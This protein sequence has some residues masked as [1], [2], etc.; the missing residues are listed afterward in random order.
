MFRSTCFHCFAVAVALLV[1]SPPSA[2]AI[3]VHRTRLVLANRLLVQWAREGWTHVALR[4]RARD[5]ARCVLPVAASWTRTPT[6]PTDSKAAGELL[7]A[8]LA[9]G[10]E[11]HERDG[12]E[13]LAPEVAAELRAMG[14]AVDAA[15]GRVS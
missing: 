9:L 5:G 1:A 10:V 13:A 3:A 12:D 2:S 4:T 6:W 15:R 8:S 14:A 7:A 11:Y